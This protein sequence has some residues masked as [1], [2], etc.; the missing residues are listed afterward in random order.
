MNPPQLIAN[1]KTIICLITIHLKSLNMKMEHYLIL[2]CANLHY[3][4]GKKCD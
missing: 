4:T 3:F 2:K 1:I